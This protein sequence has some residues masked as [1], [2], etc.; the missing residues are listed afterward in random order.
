[1]FE[2]L[3]YGLRDL[4]NDGLVKRIPDSIEELRNEVMTGVC[5]RLEQIGIE[6]VRKFMKE[7]KAVRGLGVMPFQE[8]LVVASFLGC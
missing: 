2:N 8:V 1:M 5:K 4:M 7:L 3:L 6:E